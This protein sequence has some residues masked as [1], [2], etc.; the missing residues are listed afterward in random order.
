MEPFLAVDTVEVDISTDPELPQLLQGFLV[1]AGGPQPL[2]LE[3]QLQ[4]SLLA[5][6]QYLVRI[7]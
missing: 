7:A 5:Q 3:C 2:P 4:P 1:Q 6:K